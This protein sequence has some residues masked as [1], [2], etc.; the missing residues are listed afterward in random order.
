MG[1]LDRGESKRR[2]GSGKR[3]RREGRGEGREE[4]IK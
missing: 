4:Y 2:E 1:S 3:G